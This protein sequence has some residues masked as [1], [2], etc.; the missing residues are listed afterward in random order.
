MDRLVDEI[1]SGVFSNREEFV[2]RD[3]DFNQSYLNELLFFFKPETFLVNDTKFMKNI[4]KMSFDKFQQHDVQIC[5][6]IILSGKC[7]NRFSIMD[8]HYGFI[9]KMS[10]N[11][12]KL[13]TQSEKEK[14]VDILDIRSIGGINFLGGHEFLETYSAYNED[15]LNAL[16][17]TKK[18][19][20]LRSGLYFQLYEIDNNKI[21]LVNAFQPAQLSH[22]TKESRRIVLALIRSNSHWGKL[23]NDLVGNT[24]P[25]KAVATSIRG[26]LVKNSSEYGI[27]QVSIAK[28]FTHLSAGPFEAAYEINNFINK[29]SVASYDMSLS[30]LAKNGMGLDDIKNALTNPIAEINGKE[31][32]LFT[33]TEEENTIEAIKLYN[34]YF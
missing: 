20:K 27:S 7:L 14:I 2:I 9:S 15:L 8:D 12:S 30:N 24:F 1:I 19:I 17:T 18:S 28:N 11:A 4:L 13:L 5:G 3:I 22:F 25:E 21:I 23:K 10:R 31:I 26:E 16:W 34:Q 33:M 6:V 29:L 32:D